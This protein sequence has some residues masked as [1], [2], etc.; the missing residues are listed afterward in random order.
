MACDNFSDRMAA[1]FSFASFLT[2]IDNAHERHLL[3][4]HALRE[5]NEPVLSD[6]R[7]VI[8]LQRRRGAAENDNALL[9]LCAHDC[10]VACVIPRRFLLFVGRLVFFIDNDQPEILQRREHCA[11]RADHDPGAAGMNLVPF[12]VA[13]ALGQMTVQNRDVVLRFSEP[14]FEAFHRLRRE[15][16]FGNENDGRAFPRSSAARIAC[17]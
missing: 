7:V 16:D 13:L 11:A 17:R 5:R 9:D 2:Q 15:R 10:D 12:I 8:T 3:L 14:A 1:F 6:R 4:V